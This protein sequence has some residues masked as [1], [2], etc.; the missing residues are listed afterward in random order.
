MDAWG[1][2]V[3]M[4]LDA[5]PPTQCQ[6]VCG[7]GSS[8]QYPGAHGAQSP[9]PGCLSA[10]VT[11]ELDAP[12]GAKVPMGL[13][14]LGQG[15]CGTG[16]SPQ[17]QGT[18]DAWSLSG[19]VPTGLGVPASAKV[20]MR[21]GSLGDITVGLGSPVPEWTLCW[22]PPWCQDACEACGQGGCE[23]ECS[24]G[25]NHPRRPAWPWGKAEGLGVQGDAAPHIIH[26]WGAKG[27]PQPCQ[28]LG[29]QACGIA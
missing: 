12:S 20:P 25:A 27:V 29:A 4:G 6:G 28:H 19:R 11:K 13:C 17:C 26:N 23:V 22:V 10:R 9:H 2:L 18:H 21:F 16:C 1:L 14:L 5:P 15:H 8:L 3:G 24:P 7:V